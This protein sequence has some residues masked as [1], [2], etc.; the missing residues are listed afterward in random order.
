MVSS[1]L[2]SIGFEKNPPDPEGTASVFSRV[3][4]SLDEAL[5]DLIDN[6][7]DAGASK[8]LVRFFRGSGGVRR[9]VIADNGRGMSEPDLKKA[10]QYGVRASH[11]KSDLGKYGIGLK[12]ASF[13]QCR[14]LSVISLCA[15]K[16]SGRRWTRASIRKDWRQEVIDPVYARKLLAASWSNLRLRKSGTLVV[17]DELEGLALK[18]PGGDDALTRYMKSVPIGL[19]IRFHRFL[20]SKK[21]SIALDVLD[22]RLN[23][24]GPPVFA[25]A[26]DPFGYASSGKK[27]FP[28]DFR[29]ELPNL[30][31]LVLVAHIWPRKSNDPNYKLGGG[32]VAERQGFYF[33][34]NDRLIQ[35]GGWNGVRGDSEPHLSLARVEIDMPPEMDSAFNLSVQ[36][37]KIIPP[38]TFVP[39]VHEAISGRTT[40]TEYLEAAE[41]VYRQK[42]IRG[43]SE[44]LLP[45]RGFPTRVR[46]ALGKQIPRSSPRRRISFLWERLEPERVFEPD[47]D[48]DRILLNALYRTQ[49]TGG[50]GSGADVPLVKALLLL[51]LNDEFARRRVSAARVEWLDHCNAVLLEVVKQL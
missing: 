20:S 39:A 13:S 10:M 17:W 2:P 19:G 25:V 44:V 34:R 38:P 36:K 45:A 14:S 27:G 47:R 21:L 26:L 24:A 16:A 6:S 46:K 48:S 12:A 4:H 30:G 1:D 35:T 43:P 15:G 9:I 49:I 51:M 40:F 11:K 29:V 5:A 8:V 41:E 18:G 3:G 37:S 33:Y 22:E 42:K 28:V 7:V 32:K 23:E 50:Y 31:E